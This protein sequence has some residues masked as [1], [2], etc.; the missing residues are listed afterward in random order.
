VLFARPSWHGALVNCA[1]A[2]GAEP[3]AGTRSDLR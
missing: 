3:I 2:E 1:P